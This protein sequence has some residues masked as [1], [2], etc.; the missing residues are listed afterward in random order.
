MPEITTKEGI[1]YYCAWADI[2]AF[3]KHFKVK[4][5]INSTLYLQQVQQ[6]IDKDSEYVTKYLEDKIKRMGKR[7]RTHR[8]STRAG[9]S[10]DSSRL[11]LK[12]TI[13][14]T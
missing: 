5:I 11:V 9:M 14:S 7:T 3:A 10:N 8:I 12:D 13:R 2:A 1:Q 6:C 4:Q